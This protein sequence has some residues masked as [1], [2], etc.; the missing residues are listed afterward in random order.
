[1]DTEALACNV[2]EILEDKL[3]NDIVILDVEELVGYASHFVLASGRSERQVKALAEH[4]R[5]QMKLNF[6]LPALSA[7]GLQAGRW[8]LIDFGDIVVHIFKEDERDF[9]DLEGLWRD[10]QTVERASR[11][12]VH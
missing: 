12:V 11:A 3:A 10:A 6:N 9:Y 8:A 2:A 1:M 7:E 4:T 5:D